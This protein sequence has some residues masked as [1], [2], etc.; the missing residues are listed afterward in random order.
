MNRA[1]TLPSITSSLYHRRTPGVGECNQ[2]TN[3][4][5]ASLQYIVTRIVNAGGFGPGIMQMYPVR[6]CTHIFSLPDLSAVGRGCCV[7]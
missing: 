6:L 1:G 4:A 3:I 7:H 2:G 5:L